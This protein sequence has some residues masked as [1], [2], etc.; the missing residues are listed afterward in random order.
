MHR[1]IKVESSSSVSQIYKF[2]LPKI[3]TTEK[4]C[5]TQLVLIHLHQQGFL[6][7]I[8][9]VSTKQHHAEYCKNLFSHHIK[10]LQIHQTAQGQTDLQYLSQY[11][12]SV[13]SSTKHQTSSEHCHSSSSRIRHH[14]HPSK[15]NHVFPQQGYSCYLKAMIQF[16]PHICRYRLVKA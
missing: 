15:A 2:G 5:S 9:S 4:T 10:R 8:T 12:T 11:I 6:E 14:S 13:A 1:V 3:V 7:S 16:A